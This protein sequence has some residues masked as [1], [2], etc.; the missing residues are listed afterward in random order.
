MK[1]VDHEQL[2]FKRQTDPKGTNPGKM[3][4]W[5]DPDWQPGKTRKITLYETDYAPGRNSGVAAAFRTPPCAPAPA[6]GKPRSAG[7]SLGSCCRGRGIR[8]A[9]ARR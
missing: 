4:A 8:H 3:A 9:P 1:A 7:A 6:A 2:A 5:D